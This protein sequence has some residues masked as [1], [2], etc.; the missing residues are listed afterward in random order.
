MVSSNGMGPTEFHSARKAAKA[1]GM[2][3]GLLGM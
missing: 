2:S 1:I 3:K